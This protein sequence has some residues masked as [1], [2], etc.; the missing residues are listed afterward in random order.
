MTCTLIVSGFV[1]CSQREWE[2]QQRCILFRQK[3][4][5]GMFVLL[6]F[7]LT[8]FW[9]EFI[10]IAEDSERVNESNCNYERKTA[11]MLHSDPSDEKRTP[12]FV[13]VIYAI[14][15]HDHS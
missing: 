5:D 3:F 10:G 15:D 1:F 12:K 6:I 2:K 11:R 4:G 14:I 13:C 7:T 8:M 9:C